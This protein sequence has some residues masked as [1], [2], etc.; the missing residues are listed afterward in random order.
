V[1]RD[2]Y[3]NFLEKFNISN[4]DFIEYGLNDIIFVP[5]DKVISEWDILKN[6]VYSNQEVYI[7]G[8]G[9]DATSTQYMLKVHKSLFGNSNIKKDPSNNAHPTKILENLTGFSKRKLKNSILIS[10]YQVSH[11]FGH[12]KNALMFMAPWNIVYIPKLFDP[13]SGH[14]SKGELTQIFSTKLKEITYE[15]FKVQIDD[16]NSIVNNSKFIDSLNSSIEKL[17]SNNSE[18]SQKLLNSIKDEFSEVKI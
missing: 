4:E 12:T 16:Y 14:E 18:I 17:E 1:K 6:K 5:N 7:R 9:R 10:N 13:F 15:K 3:L 8:M 11:I 2:S